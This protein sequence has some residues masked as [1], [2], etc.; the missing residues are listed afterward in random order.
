ME[1]IQYYS[2]FLD[3]YEHLGTVGSGWMNHLGRRV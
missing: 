1:E 2:P 3:V